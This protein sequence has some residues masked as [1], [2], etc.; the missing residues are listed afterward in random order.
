[1]KLSVL[2]LKQH[3]KEAGARL[4][5]LSALVYEQYSMF[6]E[7]GYEPCFLREG[8]IRVSRH[9]LLTER[10]RNQFVMFL[11]LQLVVYT[12]LFIEFLLQAM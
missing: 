3:D 9:T 2:D 12:K 4:S 8:H 11:I 6:K 1:M 5:L 7:G 10:S